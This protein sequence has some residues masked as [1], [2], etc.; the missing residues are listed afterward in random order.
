MY[1]LLSQEVLMSDIILFQEPWW[2]RIGGN[3]SD[4]DPNLEVIMGT[5]QHPTWTPFLPLQTANSH[6]PRAITFVSKAVLAQYSCSSRPNVISSEDV[7]C[8]E[9]TSRLS[10]DTFLIVNVY[11]DPLLVN[12]GAL[13]KI[14]PFR[15][16]TQIPVILAGDLNLHHPLW[17]ME[18]LATSPH[19]EE[20]VDW[21]NDNGFILFNHPAKFTFFHWNAVYSPT[22]IDLTF[23]N[24]HSLIRHWDVPIAKHI[25]SDHCAL[26]WDIDKTFQDKFE[27]PNFSIKDKNKEDWS[28]IFKRELAVSFPVYIPNCTAYIDQATIAL[29][30][31][32]LKATEEMMAWACITQW[33]MSWWNPDIDRIMMELREAKVKVK[34]TYRSGLIPQADLHSQVSKLEN[35]KKKAIWAS[36]ALWIN[37]RM[38]DADTKDI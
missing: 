11:N 10:Q 35:R 31:A 12:N 38:S 17:S 20:F 14:L 21:I 25:G 3:L 29:Q 33:S 32:V 22:I 19:A 9:V 1:A 15:P 30:D 23:V 37:Q 16:S 5:V 36:K 2:G 34:D 4:K 28:T 7:Q 24:A 8:L 13:T 27:L 18:G 6:C 26:A